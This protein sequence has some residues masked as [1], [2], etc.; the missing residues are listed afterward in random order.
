MQL[1]VVDLAA[2]VFD[3]PLCTAEVYD[4]NV[5]GAEEIGAGAGV[6]PARPFGQRILIWGMLATIRFE[7]FY[8]CKKGTA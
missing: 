3:P 5:R 2:D 8:Y 7:T 6:E 4:D 1:I